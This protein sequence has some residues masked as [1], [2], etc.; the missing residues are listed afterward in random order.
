MKN[1]LIV[2]TAVFLTVAFAHGLR[3]AYQSPLTIGSVI[4]PL[5]VSWVGVGLG[6]ALAWLNWKALSKRG[7]RAIFKL[8]LALVAIDALALLYS[9]G[10][11]LVYWGFSG[12]TFL[13]FVLLDAAII[14]ALWRALSR[15][16]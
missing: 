16:K 10:A 5:W 6:L 11:G 8:L 9:W 14:A 1:I 12:N 13:W 2:N 4:L 7:K 3:L 15:Q